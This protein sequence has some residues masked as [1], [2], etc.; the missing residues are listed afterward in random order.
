ME[1]IEEKRS[2]EN[3]YVVDQLA[4]YADRAGVYISFTQEFDVKRDG[5]ELISNRAASSRMGQGGVKLGINPRSFFST[6]IGIYAYPLKEYWHNIRE[7][8]IPF[9]KDRLNIF[10]FECKEPEKIASGSTYKIKDLIYDIRRLVNLLPENEILVDLTTVR[11]V[12]IREDSIE[13]A[14]VIKP[15]NFPNFR[16]DDKF[17]M[18]QELPGGM[19][20][21]FPKDDYYQSNTFYLPMKF[22]KIEEGDFFKDATEDYVKG[23]FKRIF[24]SEYTKVP[25]QILWTLTRKL[26]SEKPPMWTNILRQ[27]YDGIVDDEGI[28][29]IHSNEPVQG[30]FFNRKYLKVLD[31]VRNKA[32]RWVSMDEVHAKVMKKI[33]DR[34]GT[35]YGFAHQNNVIK[36]LLDLRNMGLR[37]LPDLTEYVLEGGLL[38]E[39]NPLRSLK[40]CPRII[41]GNLD[42]SDCRLES[43]EGFP[44]FVGGAV[45][46]QRNKLQSLKGLPETLYHDLRI[47]HNSLTDLNGISKYILGDLSMSANSA[48]LRSTD[49][50]FVSGSVYLDDGMPTITPRN[51]DEYPILRDIKYGDTASAAWIN[52]MEKRFEHFSSLFSLDGF[53]RP[54][55]NRMFKVGDEVVSRVVNGNPDHIWYPGTIGVVSNTDDADAGYIDVVVDDVRHYIKSSNLR[56]HVGDLAKQ[57]D[58][59]SYMENFN[60][61]YGKM[62]S[63][64]RE[65][66]KV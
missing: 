58:I 45:V 13:H 59:S 3:D 49:L 64:I 4:K 12:S 2:V 7:R 37:E 53:G 1:I 60:S 65:S 19:V 40:G 5:D 10:V 6:P 25:L 46:L 35:K 24:S 55:R 28:G 38:L 22:L 32:N 63:L 48:D 31:L 27:M 54:Y 23:V 56:P 57:K 33:E 66:V 34:L 43:L 17:V 20:S 29:F 39:D 8:D 41:G 14:N 16:V 15:D 9:A 26:A 21:I 36:G 52:A 11:Y 47:D 61:I 50:I 44:K 62:L 18:Q 51:V 42:A 30:V